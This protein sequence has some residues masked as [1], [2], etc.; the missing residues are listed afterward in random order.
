MAGMRVAVGAAPTAPADP[1]P[2]AWGT[3]S[4]TRVD[5]APA[6]VAPSPQGP[7]LLQFWA[8]WCS[9]CGRL[10]WELD[11]LSAAFPTVP[12]YAV[13]IDAE[14]ADAA[15]IRAHPLHARHPD[16]YLHDATGELA[17]RLRIDAVPAIVVLDAEGR[18]RMRHVGH[19]NSGDLMRL[20]QALAAPAISQGTPP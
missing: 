3:M 7:V 20:R 19:V 8:S 18:E 12:Y 13:S 2:I 16:R 11:G 4:L 1:P 5:G 10:M 15:R 9:S 17:R 6:A 14:P